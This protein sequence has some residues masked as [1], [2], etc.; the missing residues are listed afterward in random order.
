MTTNRNIIRIR[1]LGTAQVLGAVPPTADVI[2][3]TF[4]ASFTT[5]SASAI[6]AVLAQQVPAALKG[7]TSEGD[8]RLEHFPAADG[9]PAFVRINA[10]VGYHGTLWVKLEQL[11]EMLAWLDTHWGDARNPD[12]RQRA[13]EFHFVAHKR[14]QQPTPVALAA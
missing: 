7:T 1:G 8:W 13:G 6:A 12:W 11:D 10:D 5:T 9:C 2:S 14:K 3:A 4:T